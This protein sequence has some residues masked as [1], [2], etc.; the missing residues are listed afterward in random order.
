MSTTAE[1][2]AIAPSR[3]GKVARGKLATAYRY[4]VYGPEGVG[5]SSLAADS[6]RP[7]FVDVD[8][9]SAGLEVA[10]YLFHD[11]QGGHV[12]QSYEDVRAAIA[13]LLNNDHEFKTLVLDT[14]DRLESLLW[15]FILS[16][17]SGHATAMNK[18]GKA[19]TSIEDFGYG[20]GYQLALD[21]WRGLC[22]ALDELR[23][24]KQ[25]N[26]IILAHAQIRTF[27]SPDSEDFDR[28]SLRLN[29]KA[30][31]FLREWADVT[32]FACFE[33]SSGK[34][35]DDGRSKGYS[36]GRRLL[37]LTRTATYDAKTR[38]ALPDQVELDPAHPW[39][40][41]AQAVANNEAQTPA[42]LASAIAEELVRLNDAELTAK[43]N[44]EVAKAIKDNN[45]GALSRY[46]NALKKRQPREG[47][48]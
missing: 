14:A 31:G 26:I 40:P 2:K 46:L 16:R 6:E 39:A 23:N 30:G 41:L 27:K 7:I 35:G 45:K 9:G 17:E 25:M 47:S 8:D 12:P 15:R 3:L 22:R 13:D 43:V 21:E 10:R 29:D 42:S 44:A 37:K 19:L 11:G 48:L 18:G 28:Y 38:L 4:L 1:V 33:E 20:K 34:L 32:G 36:T 5:K 24:K